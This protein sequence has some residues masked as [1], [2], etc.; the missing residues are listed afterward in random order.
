MRLP[1]LGLLVVCWP[2]G[3]CAPV[4]AHCG[5]GVP[6]EDCR[7]LGGHSR[8]YERGNVIDA[9]GTFVAQVRPAGFIS[10]TLSQGVTGTIRGTWT[11]TGKVITMKITSA[12][13]ELLQNK[14]TTSTIVAFRQ[15]Q[16]VV[17]SVSGETSTFL[18][19]A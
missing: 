13:N 10:N 9:D 2:F 17:R 1:L 7:Q 18:R 14:V 15:D 12:E 3:L 16:L 5:V 6:G 19:A 8:R 4:L 11:L